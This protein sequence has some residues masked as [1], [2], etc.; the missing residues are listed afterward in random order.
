MPHSVQVAKDGRLAIKVRA[1][2]TGEH[3]V[4]GD[5]I[6]VVGTQKFTVPMTVKPQLPAETTVEL[7]AESLTARRDVLPIYM[8]FVGPDVFAAAETPLYY[9]HLLPTA[10]KPFQ[11]DDKGWFEWEG[12]KP[13]AS[14]VSDIRASVG[15]ESFRVE[16]SW[17]DDSPVPARTDPY[18]SRLGDPATTPLDLSSPFGQPCDA[19]EVLLDLR[20]EQSTGRC[21]ANMDSIPVGTIRAGL[22]KIDENGRIVCKLQTLP[23]SAAAACKLVE[24]GNDRYAIE[25]TG[26]PPKC[27]VGFN[28]VVTDAKEY[29]PNK[30]IGAWLTSVPLVGVDWTDFYRLSATDDAVLVRVGY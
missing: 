19:V 9:S 27:G 24:L 8:A 28:M 12:Y 25:W 6:V 15:K 13:A 18:K 26:E 16:F 30:Q 22:Y 21:T 10:A 2:L 14:T 23:E 5:L 7:P 29:A 4:V 3:A 11:R 20:D 17:H 1:A